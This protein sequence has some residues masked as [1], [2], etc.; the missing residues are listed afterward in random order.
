[1]FNPSIAGIPQAGLAE[2]IQEAVCCA[3]DDPAIQELFYA[4]IY[5]VG[6]SFKLKNIRRRLEV[7]VRRVAPEDAVVRILEMTKDGPAC[8]P[9]VC[10]W[11]GAAKLCREMPE[12]VKENSKS[13]AEYFEEGRKTTYFG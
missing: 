10:A 5:V 8:D 6:G 4:N 3:T 7:E 12:W 11:E 9:V 1:L 13:R 2:A